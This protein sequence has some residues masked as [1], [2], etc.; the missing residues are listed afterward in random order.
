MR[1]SLPYF[2][3][4]ALLTSA[5]ALTLAVVVAAR[6]GSYDGLGASDAR[7]AHDPELASLEQAALGGD[8]RAMARLGRGYARGD[9]AARDPVR[10]HAWLS[11]AAAAGDAESAVLRQDLEG[12]M[13][14][15]ELDT[16]R[17]LATSLRDEMKSPP[18]ATTMPEIQL[19]V[20]GST[21]PPA[22]GSA[23]GLGGAVALA[24]LPS[25]PATGGSDLDRAGITDL[26]WQLALHGYDPGP[27]DG[28]FGPRTRNAISTYQADAG[29]P[30]DGVATRDLLD[31]LQYD[32]PGAATDDAPWETAAATE[33][34]TPDWGQAPTEAEAADLPWAPE[35]YAQPSAPSAPVA[36]GPRRAFAIT[37]QEE[38]AARGYR[39]GPADGTVGPAT[40]SAISDYQADQGLPIDGEVSL[41]LVNHL[42]FVTTN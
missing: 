27:A 3:A 4:L 30:I 37:V 33:Q 39:V 24:S 40:R 21:T 31:R 38:L 25:A 6:A 41:A 28:S 2:V 17:R 34:V 16:A 9:G 19:P 12:N 42:R 14:P 26:Q 18:S 32:D 36:D 1:R 11:L 22:A 20:L 13:T 29:L 23:P 35:S 8:W 15:A 10:A 5:V 7:L